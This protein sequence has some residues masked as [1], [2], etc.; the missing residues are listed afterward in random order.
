MAGSEGDVTLRPRPGG[1]TMLV[2]RRSR[3]KRKVVL[4]AFE[5]MQILGVVGPAEVLDAATQV[6]GGGD[7]GYEL[8]IATLGGKPVRCSSGVQLEA[9]VALA[10]VKPREVDT[11]IVGGS[12]RFSRDGD[13]PRLRAAIR[14]ISEGARRTCSVCTGAFLLARAGLLDGRAATTHWA[15][16]DLLRQRYPRVRVRPE[17]IVV[18]EGRVC[19]AGGSTSFLNLTLHLIERWLGA[20]V[21]RL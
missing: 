1:A 9:D 8:S 6:L 2:M 7:R 17:A 20:D 10:H 21:A 5:R 13:D 16:Q 3:G 19:T 12:M 15:F 11:L 4:V 18:D 14:R